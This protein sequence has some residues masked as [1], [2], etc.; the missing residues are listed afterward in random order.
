VPSRRT[1]APSRNPPRP[2]SNTPDRS[3]T[4]RAARDS[5]RPRFPLR[6]RSGTT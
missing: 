5:K 1:P 6:P 3:A 4:S 2:S